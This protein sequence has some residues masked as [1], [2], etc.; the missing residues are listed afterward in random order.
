MYKVEKFKSGIKKFFQNVE[1]YL[2]EAGISWEPDDVDSWYQEEGE[3]EEETQ[4]ECDIW[5]EGHLTH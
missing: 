5:Y 1:N 2:D 3:E 4:E